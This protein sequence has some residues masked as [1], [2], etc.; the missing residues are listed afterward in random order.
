[1][2]KTGIFMFEY[3]CFYIARRM[4]GNRRLIWV[5]QQNVIKLH[6]FPNLKIDMLRRGHC[7][8]FTQFT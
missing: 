5:I 8:D 6:V 4:F 2:L 1:M 7:T 3:K